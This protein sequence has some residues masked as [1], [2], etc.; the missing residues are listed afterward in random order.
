MTQRQEY[1]ACIP[2]ARLLACAVSLALL[3]LPYPALLSPAA[4]PSSL[5]SFLCA[6][7]CV[8]ACDCFGISLVPFRLDSGVSLIRFGLVLVSVPGHL[9]AVGPVLMSAT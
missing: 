6:R 3:T 2:C 8:R 7:A 4:T 1:A 5:F 9:V